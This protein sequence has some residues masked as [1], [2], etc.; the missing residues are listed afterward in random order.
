MA[1]ARAIKVLVAG[2]LGLPVFSV[3]AADVRSRPIGDMSLTMTPKVTACMI[4]RNSKFIISWLQAMPGSASERQL[5]D[6]NS[7]GISYCYGFV[8]AQAPD[9]VPKH[10]YSAMRV[11]LVRFL[12]KNELVTLPDTM[13]PQ[14][15]FSAWYDSEAAGAGNT[16][17]TASVLANAMGFCLAK[18]NWSAARSLVVSEI[19]STAEVKGI[20]ALVPL[21]SGC[22]PAG[23]R[24]AVDRARLRAIME[25]TAYHAAGGATP[26]GLT[27]ALASNRKWIDAHPYR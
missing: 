16:T 13:P 22:I 3:T 4:R 8:A 11:T 20:A 7:T 27:A 21:I 9:W 12:V 26:S 15:N 24:L 2:T 17:S 25:E 5:L 14:A 1:S 6:R 19:G 10:D 23:I 18:S